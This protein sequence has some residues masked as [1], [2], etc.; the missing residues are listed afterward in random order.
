MLSS[1]TFSIS[2]LCDQLLDISFIFRTSSGQ[3]DTHA[4]QAIHFSLSASPDSASM[5]PVGHTH[6]SQVDTKV[7]NARTIIRNYKK[8]ILQSESTV[9]RF[10]EFVGEEENKC[11]NR[12]FEYR[13][14]NTCVR[15]SAPPEYFSK[16]HTFSDKYFIPPMELTNDKNNCTEFEER[17]PEI[18]MEARQLKEELRKVNQKTIEEITL[19][20]KPEVH[21]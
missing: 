19:Y 2:N 4:K 18:E 14:A 9:L 6:T 7:D 21:S 16:K 20:S 12:L 17:L 5:A 1:V 15:D 3:L 11:N 10:N 8:S 13:D